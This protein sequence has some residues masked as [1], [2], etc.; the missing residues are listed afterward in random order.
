MVELVQDANTVEPMGVFTPVPLDD[1]EAMI[2]ASEKKD[3][4]SGTGSYLNLTIEIIGDNEFKGRKIFDTLNLV[5]P[6]PQTVEIAQRRLS[7]IQ[8]CV[9]VIHLRDSNEL[10]NIPLVI[11]VGIKPADGQYAAKNIIR[12]FSRIDGKE[13][14]DVV[15]EKPI[16]KVTTPAASGKPLKPWQKK[17]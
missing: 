3:T 11:S 1:Y 5:N 6:N 15:D 4:K 10:H 7:S 2:V 12:G 14:K 9:G 16:A 13:L 8:R 17:A